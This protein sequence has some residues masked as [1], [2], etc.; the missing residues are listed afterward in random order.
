MIFNVIRE[1]KILTKN[2]F[3]VTL[4]I[5]HVF[6]FFFFFFLSSE[7]FKITFFGKLYFRNIIRVSNKLGPDQVLHFARPGLGQNCLQRLTADDTN[8]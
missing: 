1:N 3:P 8:R 4:H 7:F 6:F 2:E 5:L